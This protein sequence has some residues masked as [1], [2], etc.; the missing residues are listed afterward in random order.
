MKDVKIGPFCQLNM[1]E[2]KTQ[3]II[4]MIILNTIF[5]KKNCLPRINLL[6]S[7]YE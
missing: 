3:V 2:G 6:T 1:G 7:L 5:S 4:P